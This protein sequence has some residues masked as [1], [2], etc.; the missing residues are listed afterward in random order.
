MTTTV[1]FEEQIE[2]PLDIPSLADFRR[3]AVLDQ[4]PKTG[5]VRLDLREKASP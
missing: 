4:F 1:L 5:R 2:I 3:W